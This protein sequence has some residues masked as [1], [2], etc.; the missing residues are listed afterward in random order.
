MHFL[1]LKIGPNLGTLSK[2]A[3]IATIFNSPLVSCY[4][5]NIDFL[6]LHSANFVKRI[7]FS[8]YT[9]N[10][11]DKCFIAGLKSLNNC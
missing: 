11:A 1:P 8:F 5:I 3:F 10:K 9:S 4:L 6:M 7:V 2:S